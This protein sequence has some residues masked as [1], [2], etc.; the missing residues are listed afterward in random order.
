VSTPPPKLDYR[1]AVRVDHPVSSPS[2]RRLVAAFA[3]FMGLITIIP[4]FSRFYFL[5]TYAGHPINRVFWPV[6]WHVNVFATSLIIGGVLLLTRW[7]HGRW[8]LLLGSAVQLFVA[9]FRLA[10]T[11]SCNQFAS[12]GLPITRILGADI[13]VALVFTLLMSP[14]IFRLLTGRT[15]VTSKDSLSSA[16]LASL[17]ILLGLAAAQ[18]YDK[19]NS[20][21]RMVYLV[22]THVGGWPWSVFAMA[23]RVETMIALIMPFV[24]LLWVLRPVHL[25]LTVITLLGATVVCRLI[26]LIILATSS[27]RASAGISP[28]EWI[29]V[30]DDFQ[31]LHVNSVVGLW[32]LAR[33]VIGPRTA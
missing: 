22:S 23:N 4:N 21:A 15:S 13:V 31:R 29:L 1:H 26:A 5:S 9:G 24:L 17:V 3:I 25:H 27:T 33:V 32:L 20:F 16:C 2:N 14:P 11:L 19:T 10:E 28:P 8:I 30:L 12:S 7:N 6:P 18:H